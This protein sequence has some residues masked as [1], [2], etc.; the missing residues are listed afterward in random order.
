MRLVII[1]DTHGLHPWLNMPEGDV[2]IHAGD[3]CHGF[4]SVAE[5]KRFADWIAEQPYAAKIV[6]AGN[7]D[8]PAQ[9]NEARCRGNFRKRGV[10]YLRDSGV[11]IDGVSFWG[12]P[13]QPEY[14]GMAF[15]L[16]RGDDLWDKWRRIP[17]ALD[18]L[19]THG[20]PLGILDN[21]TSPDDLFGEDR[22]VGCK[23]LLRRVR[24]VKPKLHCF[25]HIHV[26]HGRE[27]ID[28]TC[29]INA[30]NASGHMAMGMKLS[31]ELVEK[32]SFR[33]DPVVF[34]LETP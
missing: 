9:D 31:E 34:D 23:Q 30:A 16:P 32:T 1:S 20:P 11:D 4:G 19:I 26:S 5:M 7:H 14:G 21:A 24:Q 3:W 8:F 15:N 12:S 2:L 22:S 29:F 13:W 27:E 25:G 18:V 17:K 6:I 28:G 10:H 33:R